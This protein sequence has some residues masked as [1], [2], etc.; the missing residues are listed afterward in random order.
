MRGREG[1]RDGMIIPTYNMDRILWNDPKLVRER[2]D[3][4]AG[5]SERIFRLQRDGLKRAA[6]G[7]KRE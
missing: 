6:W 4:D 5:A 7:R 2:E 1:E 3:E